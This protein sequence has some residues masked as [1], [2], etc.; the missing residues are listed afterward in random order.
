MTDIENAG[1]MIR[2][3]VAAVA[4]GEDQSIKR[5]Q[6]AGG[7]VNINRNTSSIFLTTVVYF[8]HALVNCYATATRDTKNV[9]TA[10]KCIPI[11]PHRR[12]TRHPLRKF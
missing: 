8:Q 2:L 1:D 6:A 12:Y 4:I 9:F 5:A 3:Y 11:D 10:A 7:K